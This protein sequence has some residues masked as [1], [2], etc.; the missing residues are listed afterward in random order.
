MARGWPTWAVSWRYSR[1]SWSSSLAR[2]FN[3]RL[4]PKVGTELV[5]TAVTSAEQRRFPAQFELW[6]ERSRPDSV[7][8]AR[9]RDST[10]YHYWDVY[11]DS[12]ALSVHPT[13]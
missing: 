6:R 13:C 12:L 1:W 9:S 2:S 7:P 5:A 4:K 3:D 8:M 11:T 10:F